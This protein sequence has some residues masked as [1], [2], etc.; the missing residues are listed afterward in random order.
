MKRR[1]F[2]RQS[3]LAS[4]GFTGIS[5][6]GARI[7]SNRLPDEASKGKILLRIGICADLH[8]DIINDA[9]RR[10]AAFIT[11]MNELK[12][13]YIIQLGDFCE[14][15]ESNQIIMDIWNRFKGPKYHVIG[16]H[17]VDGGFTHDQVVNFWNAEGKYYS[18]EMKG[19][20]FIVL[21]GNEKG[22]GYS[23]YPRS[24]SEQQRNWLEE[25]INSTSLPIIVYCHQAID[26][27]ADG[28]DQGIW[29]R[30]LFDRANK[31]AG[32][33]KVQ[34]VFSGHHHQDWCN[35]YNKIHYVQINSMSYQW[36]GSKY[37]RKRFD[38]SIEN[39]YPVVRY[40]APYKDPIWAFLTIYAGGEFIIKGKRS[41]F[42]SPGPKEMNRPELHGAYPDVP[43]VS[44]RKLR[45]ENTI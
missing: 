20:H 3:T 9:P 6:T 2:L 30:A 4:L 1:N 12:P 23:G 16:N 45:V 5:K 37:A 26:N 36:M 14:P 32:F 44:D 41:V 34:L 35:E 38:D 19:Y 29:I 43:Y 7:N 31:K 24:I 15:K 33:T 10:L 8:Q 42:I 21:N 27:D 13:N 18:F 17:D 11:E 40:T 28:I 25:D 39:K 22:E